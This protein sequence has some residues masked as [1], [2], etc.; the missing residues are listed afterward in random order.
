VE[1]VAH[2]DA[3]ASSL[4][5]VGGTNAPARGAD[6]VGPAFAPLVQ[7]DVV[8]KDDV[9]LV[10]DEQAAGQVEAAGAKALKLNQEDVQVQDDARADHEEALGMEGAAGDL[11]EG[12][13]DAVHDHRVAGI[14]AALEA[15]HVL[16]TR[17]EKVDE[18][19]LAFVAPL[20]TQ[21]G[22]VLRKTAHEFTPILQNTLSCALLPA[23]IPARGPG[24]NRG[25]KAQMRLPFNVRSSLHR[26][27]V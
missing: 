2:T 27:A 13:A 1:E 23:G 9:G 16:E 25:H 5:L 26:W 11:V 19:A 18:L 10:A 15:D 20:Q 8:G 21:D 22:Q 12:D 4:H 14:V 24:T 7:G 6:L 3:H 17:A